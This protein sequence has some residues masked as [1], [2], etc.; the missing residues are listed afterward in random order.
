MK[1]HDRFMRDQARMSGRIMKDPREEQRGDSGFPHTVF[2]R[3]IPLQNREVEEE[4]PFGRRGPHNR[5]M[6]EMDP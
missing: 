6:E 1:S 5:D 3:K 2:K 4:M